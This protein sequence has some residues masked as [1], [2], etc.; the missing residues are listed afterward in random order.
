METSFVDSYSTSYAE[1]QGHP[2]PQ[3]L[4][5]LRSRAERPLRSHEALLPAALGSAAASSAGARGQLQPGDVQ[6]LPRFGIRHDPPPDRSAGLQPAAG[7]SAGGDGVLAQRGRAR[8]PG[9]G[10]RVRRRGEQPE[11]A[12]QGSLREGQGGLRVRPQGQEAELAHQ[13]PLRR[14]TGGQLR[15]GQWDVTSTCRLYK[16]IS[17]ILHVLYV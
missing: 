14:S 6:L 8:V 9:R 13:A 3:N 7:R 16:C 17:I 10:A 12:L 4:L 2:A 15:A 1:Q 11:E 5:K